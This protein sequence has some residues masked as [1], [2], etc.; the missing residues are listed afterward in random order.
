MISKLTTWGRT[1]DEAIRRMERALTEYDVA[2]MQTTIPFCLFVM[3]HE[4]FRTGQFS[5]HFVEDH[6]DPNA[7]TPD[8]PELDQAAALAATLFRAQREATTTNGEAL[9]DTPA[10][11]AV[12]LWRQ[13]R[14]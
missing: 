8:N 1:R 9:P 13:R 12:S 11:P 3:Q 10:T 7:L 5:T 2:G 14:L 6:F 4:A